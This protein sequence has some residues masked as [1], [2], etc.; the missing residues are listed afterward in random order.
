MSRIIEEPKQHIH[1]NLVGELNEMSIRIK[2]WQDSTIRGVDE[3]QVAAIRRFRSMNSEPKIS[4]ILDLID[5]CR[6][7]MNQCTKP[8][9]IH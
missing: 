8:Y 9:K 2:M 4:E 1:D 3:N 7:E 6:D 5:R